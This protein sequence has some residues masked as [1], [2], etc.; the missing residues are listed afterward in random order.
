MKWAD[1]GRRFGGVF[2]RTWRDIPGD[3][4]S[5][6]GRSEFEPADFSLIEDVAQLM[7]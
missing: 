1:A 4:R 6:R 3:G 7:E 5:G 2:G